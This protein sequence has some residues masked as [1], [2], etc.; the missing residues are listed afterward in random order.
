MPTIRFSRPFSS[1]SRPTPDVYDHFLDSNGFYRK[2]T[3]R[4]AS[5]LFRVIS[6]QLYDTQDH[7]QVSVET[8]ALWHENH[9]SLKNENEI[10]HI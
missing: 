3:A 10:E 6:E 4:D 1:G 9:I 5:N 8:F 7:H 2:H